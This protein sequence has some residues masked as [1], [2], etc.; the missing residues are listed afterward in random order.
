MQKLALFGSACALSVSALLACSS[1][2]TLPGSPDPGSSGGPTDQDASTFVR[3]GSTYDS[4][5]SPE[6]GLGTLLFRPDQVFS[7]IDGTHT[8]KVPLAVYDSSADLTVTASDP[9]A[10]TVAPTTLKN[11]VNPDGITDNGKYFMITAQKA[12]TFKLTASSS[13]RSVTATVTVTD[14]AANRWDDGHARYYDNVTTMTA[15][16]ACANCH[17]NGLAIDHSPAALATATDQEIG[18]IITTGVK[19]GPSVIK[20]P[21]EPGTQH[22]WTVTPTEQAGLVTFLRALDPRGFQ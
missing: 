10:L 19:P 9:S 2:T 6:S 14:Y 7:G 17:V 13:G 21:N 4:A 1:S 12:G 18:I 15:D 3:D 5:V 11:P 8:F 22:K 16:R 20:I